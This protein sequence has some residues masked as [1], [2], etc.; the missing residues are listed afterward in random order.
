MN[1]K[2]SGISIGLEE[3][4]YTVVYKNNNNNENLKQ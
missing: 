3:R 4:F 2:C 1:P